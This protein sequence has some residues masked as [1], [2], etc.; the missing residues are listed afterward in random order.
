MRLFLRVILLVLTL[1]FSAQ[2][3]FALPQ[4]LLD[5]RTGEVLFE[6]DAGV[7]WHPASLTK[8]MTAYA[9]FEAVDSGRL[10][11]E[12]PVV[13]TAN[14]LKAPPSKMGFPVGTAVTLEDALYLMLVKSANDV[15][16]AI[17]ETVG[18]SEAE[19][20]NLMNTHAANL[21]LTNTRFA[22]ANGLHDPNQ[23]T[24]ARDIAILAFVIRS[25]YPQYDKIFETRAVKFGKSTLKSFN[26]LL[27]KFR[28]TTGMKTG[29][30]CA[31]GLNIVAT[32]QRNGREL[33][34]VVMGGVSARERGEMA[35]L[36]LERGFQGRYPGERKS[37]TNIQNLAMLPPDMRPQMCGAEAKS[38]LESRK[39]AF[40]FG[41]E[42]QISYLNDDVEERAVRVNTLGKIVDVDLPRPRPAYAFVPKSIELP[43]PRPVV[44]R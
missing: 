15:A 12:T 3:S 13:M 43:R 19:F 4:L 11:L 31:S 20:V 32:A 26:V 21:G 41:L 29:Y 37:V 35:A 9:A 40:P 36:L 39:V 17:G 14:A 10:T 34:A 22:N 38:Y 23:I 25:R 2:P 44:L 18:G 8:L 28:G 33:M 16:T 6:K 27:E 42:G 30:V 24:S 5:M 1:G 7:P